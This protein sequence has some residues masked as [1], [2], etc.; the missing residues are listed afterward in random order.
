M[1][2]INTLLLY[3][4]DNLDGNSSDVCTDNRFFYEEMLF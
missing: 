2:T 1:P 3:R 4:K